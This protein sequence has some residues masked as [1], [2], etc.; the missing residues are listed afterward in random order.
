[1]QNA[2]QDDSSVFLTFAPPGVSICGIVRM[3]LLL[4]LL[5]LV[6]SGLGSKNTSV[7][8]FSELLPDINSGMFWAL[9]VYGRMYLQCFS[10]F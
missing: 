2:A 8:C 10:T 6:A 7:T 5:N 3:L 1:M 9:P 4:L